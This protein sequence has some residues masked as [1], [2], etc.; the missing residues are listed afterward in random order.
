MF[1]DRMGE[2]KDRQH[3]HTL[4]ARLIAGQTPSGGWAYKVPK[5]VPTTRV[6]NALKTLNPPQPPVGFSYRERPPA[7]GLCIKTSDDVRVKPALA[8]PADPEKARAAVV[9][10]LPESARYPVFS[11]PNKLVMQDPPNK[12]H[13][14]QYGTTDNSNT[15]FAI[16]GLW[17]ARRHEVPVERSFALMNRRF[18]TSQNGDGSWNYGYVK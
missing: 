8:T 18:R 12:G 4:S 16:L 2:Q 10:A 13:D 7:L 3:I 17:A 14:P 5:V 6:L 9:K 15:H 1:L 11:N